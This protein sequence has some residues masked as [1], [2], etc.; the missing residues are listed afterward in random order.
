MLFDRIPAC[1]DNRGMKL[2]TIANWIAAICA[3]IATL[4]CHQLLLKHVTGSASAAWFDLGCSDKQGAGSADCG[5]VLASP[6]SYFPPKHANEPPNQPHIPVAFIGLLYYSTMFVWLVGV[7]RPAYSRRRMHYA[8]FLLVLLGLCG[9]AYFVFIMFKVIS[10][11]CVWCAATHGLNAAIAICMILMWPR[12]GRFAVAGFPTR[13]AD[14][15]TDGT[16]VASP[17]TYPSLQHPTT[18]VLVLTLL[19]ILIVNYAQLNVLGVKT[20]RKKAEDAATINK[21]CMS[22]V[23]KLKGDTESQ[24]RRWEA[25][26]QHQIPVGEKDAVRTY[27]VD[28]SSGSTGVAPLTVVVFSDF[29]CPGCGRFARFFEEHVP[30][31]FGGNVRAV[32]KHYPL[33]RTCN[34]LSSKTMHPHACEAMKWT[35]S[36]RTLGG[37]AAFWKAH[38]YVF[39]NQ[40][41]L[42]RG[43]LKAE[44]VAQAAGV[45]VEKFRAG[46]GGADIQ[47]TLD[48]HLEEARMLEIRGT[49]AIFVEG[50]HVDSTMAIDAAFWERMAEWH[51]GRVSAQKP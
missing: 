3:L 12:A 22:A 9:S 18:R 24:F 30:K 32:F 45:D 46:M 21:Q 34:T 20:W 14:L 31:I 43:A 33:D 7:G 49:P 36:A 51:K 40:E 13:D 4:I 28:E 26:K 47:S 2:G 23:E 38:D 48:N 37:S 42:K 8:A 5:A 50:R 41:S 27:T 6:Y 39:A 16:D 44:A 15:E 35:E 17:L 1:G 10:E 25:G 11:W 29:E 19:G